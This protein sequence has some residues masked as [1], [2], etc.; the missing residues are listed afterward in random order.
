[1]FEKIQKYFTC[2]KEEKYE[3][4]VFKNNKKNPPKAT[5]LKYFIS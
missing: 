1:M 5:F 2:N 4:G 3:R